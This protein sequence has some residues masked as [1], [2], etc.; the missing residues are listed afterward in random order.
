MKGS[1]QA[2][3]R[4]A[5]RYDQGVSEPVA[6]DLILRMAPDGRATVCD[7]ITLRPFAGPMALQDALKY[8][9]MMG[10]QN[11]WRERVDARGRPLGDPVLLPHREFD[12]AEEG[13]Q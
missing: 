3:W 4:Q 12:T 13:N 2:D 8:A 7:A 10:P 11:L 5:S 1:D 9:A 6:G